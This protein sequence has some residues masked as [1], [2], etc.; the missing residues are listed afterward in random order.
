MCQNV[1]SP[2]YKENNVGK[3]MAKNHIIKFVVSK[4]QKEKILFN[5]RADGYTTISSY[6]RNLLLNTNLI[7]KIYDTVKRIENG[8]NT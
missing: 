1:S 4:D 3:I 2:I 6:A 8:K 7:A 5:A